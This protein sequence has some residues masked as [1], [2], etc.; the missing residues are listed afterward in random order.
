SRR[1]GRVVRVR[2]DVGGDLRV[3]AGA[4]GVA[5]AI[6]GELP[7]GIAVVHRMAADAGER[8]FLRAARFDE[9]VVLAAGDADHAVLPV[10]ALREASV[11]GDLIAAG[12]LGERGE[13]QDRLVGGERAAGAE[14]EAALEPAVGRAGDAVALAADLGALLWR[15]TRGIDDGGVGGAACVQRPATERIAIGGDVGGR[16][17]VAR[18]ARDAEFGDARVRQRGARIEAGDAAGRMTLDADAV[19][20]RRAL[21]VFGADEEDVAARDP[22]RVVEEVGERELDELVGPAA[23]EPERLHVVRAGEHGDAAR[24]DAGDVGPQLVA[25]AAQ[26]VGAAVVVGAQRFAGERG[27]H[28]RGGRRL[29]HGAVVAAM[30]RGVLRRVAG[31]A[32]VGA[33]VA[34]IG[35]GRGQGG[36]VAGGGVATGGVARAPGDGGG[37]AGGGERGGEGERGRARG[38]TD[39]HD[40]GGAGEREEAERLQAGPL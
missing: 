9:A 14:G 2:R 30:P 22:A 35:D 33:D 31:L 1:A 11:G 40:D 6:A 28:R 12:A 21:G 37:G 39:E 29:R 10:A 5:I 23:G 16:R 15:K 24:A 36:G 4:R 18:F 20:N 7:V 3:A 32:G 13:A 38:A 27:A 17:A 8:A 26:A 34:A 25:V 19:P